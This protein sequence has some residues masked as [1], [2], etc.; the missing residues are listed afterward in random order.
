MQGEKRGG[1]GAPRA[2]GGG[3][4]AGAPAA[5]VAKAVKKLAAWHGT[6]AVTVAHAPPELEKALA[7]V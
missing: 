3:G 4:G 5:D 1:G 7:G 2:G 6:P